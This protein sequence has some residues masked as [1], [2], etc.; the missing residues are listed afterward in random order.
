MSGAAMMVRAIAASA[1][2]RVRQPTCASVPSGEAGHA[3]TRARVGL[4][5]QLPAN[6][7]GMRIDPPPSVPRWMLP[8]PRTTAATAPPEEPPGV[9][10]VSHG[11]RVTP[12][13]GL[14]VTP[15]QPNSG[16]VVLPTTIAPCSLRRA[17]VGAS[18]AADASDVSFD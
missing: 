8:M 10:R 12:V 14:S 18:C 11:L 4:I 13:N 17:T 15:F 3:G 5:P 2:D 1:T 9:L 7:A 6:A 16:I